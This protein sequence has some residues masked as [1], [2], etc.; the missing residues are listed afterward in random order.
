[1]RRISKCLALAAVLA[2]CDSATDSVDPASSS[3]G[4][5]AFAAAGALVDPSSLT[6]PPPPGAVCRADGAGTICHTEVS[7]PSVNDPVFD[8]PCGTVYETGSD[9]RHGI[10]WYN[11]DNKLVKRFVTQDAEATW[12]LSPTGAG[13]TVTATTHANWRNDYAVP[14][15]VSTGPQVTHGDGLTVQAPG[16]GV[17]AHIAGLD[18]PDGPHR[19]IFH[20]IDDP[21]VAAKLCAALTR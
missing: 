20:D 14:G 7:F 3:T 5:P 6:P 10:R 19:G 17:I 15:D 21:A 9:V 18:P 2:G 16:F 4:T 13:P 11:S 8:L 12:S 1:M